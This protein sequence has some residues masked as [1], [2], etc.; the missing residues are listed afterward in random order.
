MV[1]CI[2][3]VAACGSSDDNP[4]GP[5][6]TGPGQ[7]AQGTTL[8][9]W[10]HDELLAAFERVLIAE[11]DLSECER[12][13]P[14][15]DCMQLNSLEISQLTSHADNIVVQLDRLDAEVS[16]RPSAVADLETEMRSDLTTLTDT[17]NNIDLMCVSYSSEECATALDEFAARLAA[18]YSTILDLRTAI[19]LP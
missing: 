3:A 16:D 13:Q 6:G 7:N 9:A 1:S 10:P 5:T 4:S 2:V 8:A 11:S 19:L 12:T 17:V 15:A 18:A 14:R